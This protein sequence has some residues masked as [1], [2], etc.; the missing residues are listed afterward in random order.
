MSDS[1][2]DVE[3]TAAAPTGTDGVPTVNALST[4]IRQL[5]NLL[6]KVI[7]EQHGIEAFN[8]V[9]RVRK[10]AKDRRGGDTEAEKLLRDTIDTLDLES[11]RILIKAFSN[12]FQLINIAE[13][14]Q[15]IRMLRAREAAGELHESIGSAI[16]DLR[17]AG[18]DAVGVRALLE[19]TRTR[20]VMTAHPS[21]AK[22]KEVLIKLFHIAQMMHRLDSPRL[23]P[24]EKRV[25]EA[26]LSEEIEELWQTRPTRAS[27]PTPADEVDFGMYFITSVIM[28]VVLDVYDELQAALETYYPEDDW[29]DLPGVLQYAS[30]I[31]GDRDGNPNVTADVTME[32]LAQQ[33]SAARLSYL[34]EIAHLRDHLTQSSDEVGM[35]DALIERL[36]RT[37]YPDSAPDE[38][39]RLMMDIIWHK[40]NKEEY[41][42]GD[43]L[44]EDL[45]LVA[46]SLRQNQGLNVVKGTLGRLMRKIKLFG[47]HLVPLDVREDARLHRAAVEELMRAYG[48]TDDYNALPETD[49]QKMLTDEIGNPRPFFP[50]EPNFSDITNRVIATWRMIA[51]AHRRYGKH[52]IDSVIASMSTAP[53]DILTMLMFAKEVGVQND[54]DVVPLFETIDDLQAAPDI[55]RTLF[56]NPVYMNHVA[57]RGMRQQIMLG[58]SDSNKDGGYLAS[59]WNLYVAQQS[60]SDV[61]AAFGVELELFHGRGGSIGRGGGPANRAIL[62]QPPGTMRGKIKMTEQGEVIA[63]RYTNVD[64]G[65]RHLHQV[66]NAVLL[67]GGLSSVG[68]IRPEWRA[69]MNQLAT[70]GQRAYR[71]LVYETPG[72]IDYWQQATP[73]NELARMPIGSRPAKRSKGGFESIRAIPWMFSWMQSRAIIPSWYGVGTAIQT[74][75]DSHDGGLELLKTM[76]KEWMFFRNLV[77]NAELDL[78]KADMGIAQLYAEL[79]TDDSLRDQIFS[80]LETEHARSCAMICAITGESE[81]LANAPTMQRSIERRNPYVDPLNYIQVALLRDVRSQ[82]PGTEEYEKLLN[83]MLTTINGIA[84]GMKTTG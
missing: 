7:R 69:A 52:A 32:T 6:G 64:I 30:W 36:Q 82:Y 25:I 27:R 79:V 84:A 55:M 61:C 17:D 26:S 35:S 45:N 53:S 72:F 66:L 15:R 57:A 18:M 24:R 2:S 81:L 19:R 38:K 62:S 29:S 54:V 68:E 14:Q 58:Y 46:D 75:C 22:R 1:K 3:Q 23:L 67:A 28:D 74:F 8:L 50:I 63:Y 70:T 49:K 42:T 56:E 51:K 76:F 31:G 73:I 59:N 83:V 21:E 71:S 37:P 44:L 41:P 48:Q 9:E 34:K 11:R 77:E 20:L 16:R 60:L 33:R 80:Q 43:S 5:G 65:R 12:Y 10:A 40:L 39:Y 13:D 4:D 47:L 78:T